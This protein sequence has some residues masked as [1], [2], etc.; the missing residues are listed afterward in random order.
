MESKAELEKNHCIVSIPKSLEEA[1]KCKLTDL[2]F[3]RL[4]LPV[5]L[6]IDKLEEFFNQNKIGNVP[7][8]TA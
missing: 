5:N 3:I 2:T 6:T 8:H 7:W 1:K 4:N